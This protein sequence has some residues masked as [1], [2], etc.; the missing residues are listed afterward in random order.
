MA[1]HATQQLRVN[2]CTIEIM[3]GGSGEPL[4]YLHGAGGSKGW[5]PF[6]DQLSD[7]FSVLAPDHPGFGNSDTP[8]WLD[9][10]TDL[11]Y[12]YLDLL[13]QLDLRDVHLV[14]HSMGGWLATELAVRGTG[15]IR[16]LTL[17][18]SAGIRVPGVPM[19]DLFM[20][21]AEQKARRMVFDQ[22]VG[23]QRANA[24]L[25]PEEAD[26]ALKNAF[27]SSKLCWS[28]RFHNPD[29]EKWLHRIKMPTMIM[30]GENDPIFPPPYAHAYKE[31]IAGSELR[32]FSECAHS[33]QQEQLDQFMAG[34]DAITEKS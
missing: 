27:T 12:F 34:I 4:L 26:R 31:L 5:A 25:T 19:G 9:S 1:D 24:V 29:L 28:P 6:L 3:K 21:S 10:M 15:R 11:V 7:R 2:D 13:E 16:T 23:E 17:V 33:P 18:S 30:W 8:G 14:G 20:W 32:I 22:A